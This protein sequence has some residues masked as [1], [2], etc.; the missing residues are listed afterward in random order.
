[1]NKYYSHFD[2]ADCIQVNMSKINKDIKSG[3]GKPKSV[4][5]KYR[6][7]NKSEKNTSAMTNPSPFK[8][9]ERQSL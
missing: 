1:M 4:Y 2:P 6:N 3:S 7:K 9:V 8:A 5:M